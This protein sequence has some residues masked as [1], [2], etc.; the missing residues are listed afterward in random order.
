MKNIKDGYFTIKRGE[1]KGKKLHFSMNC[2][3]ELKE[4]TGKGIIEWTEDYDKGGVIEQ[5]LHIG[6]I[7][8]ASAKAYDLEEGNEI[9]YNLYKARSWVDSFNEDDSA[10]FVKA[11]T[12]GIS[13]NLGK[14]TGKQK[15]AVKK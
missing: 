3:A 6:D 14:P 10:D 11:L 13:P 8:Y 7:V 1:G 5:A 9:D 15:P 4:E 2:W 12:W